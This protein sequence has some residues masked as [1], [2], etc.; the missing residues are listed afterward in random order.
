MSLHRL[1]LGLLYLLTVALMVYLV[2]MGAGYYGSALTERPHNTL[3]EVLRP[4]GS[5]G[6]GLGIVGSILMLILLLYSVRKRA[7]FMQNKGDIR[8]W[9]NYHIW[10]GVTGPLLV[11][12]HT[13]FKLGGIV[14]VSFWSM[15][16]VAL[17]GVL[18]RYIYVQIPRTL[19][20]HE[21][22]VRELEDLDST[23]M[24]EL[25]DNFKVDA[26]TLALIQDAS[27]GT[28]RTAR[29][30]WSGLWAWAMDDLAL[31]FRLR[32]VKRSLRA[33]TALN[34]R[35]IQRV[36]K[37]ARDKVKLRRR[38]AFLSTA[39]S[40]LHHWHIIHRPFAAVMLII[41]VVH[42]VVS[43]LF[44]YRWIFGAHASPLP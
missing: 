6:H 36:M 21:L 24:Q 12:F 43:I 27:S 11:I 38:A 2:L 39:H 4:S 23:L 35:E 26:T 33:R 25:K 34:S 10:M 22:S 44:G 15:I 28:P 40:L 37:I 17:S 16:G 5:I 7:R 29:G 1:S 3:H 13:A 32:A 18:G 31:P 8:Y 42:V 20:G 41:M 30:G 19:G 14:A 9:L